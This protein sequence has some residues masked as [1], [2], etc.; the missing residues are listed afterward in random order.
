MP[1]PFSQFHRG[2][3]PKYKL[4]PIAIA[5]RP[6]L[7]VAVA[8]AIAIWAYVEQELGSLLVKI[9]GGDAGPS[10]A[11]YGA[12]VSTAAQNAALNAAA[13]AV[14]SPAVHKRFLAVKRAGPRL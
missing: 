4:G 7:A 14:L 10:L 5:E 13:E 2:E 8:Q 11:M 1:Q 3:F 9:L 6:V 12:L